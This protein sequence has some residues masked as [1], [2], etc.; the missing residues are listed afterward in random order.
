MLKKII[1]FVRTACAAS[2][3]CI[4]ASL[5]KHDSAATHQ[6]DTVPPVYKHFLKNSDGQEIPPCS[7]KSNT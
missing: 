4:M 7:L 2:V 5:A 1:F 3:S 6:L